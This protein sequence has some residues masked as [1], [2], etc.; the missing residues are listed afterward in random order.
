MTILKTQTPHEFLIRWDDA[1]ALKGA[2]IAFRESIT[3]DGAEISSKFTAPQAVAMAGATG[4]P[5]ADVIGL[6][7]VDA[8]AALDAK[9]AQIATLTAERDAAL[10]GQPAPG[11]GQT[12]SKKQGRAQLKVEGLLVA[13]EAYIMSLP[14]DDDTRMAYEDSLNWERT[15]PNVIGM[16]GMLGKTDADADAFFTAAALL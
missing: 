1:G 11:N 4:F 9:D 5:L 3:E 16:M 10:A 8:L 12:I 14:S 6:L 7:S 2:H 13:V 15:D